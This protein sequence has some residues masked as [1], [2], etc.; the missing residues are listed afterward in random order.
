[1]NAATD[2]AMGALLGLAIGDALGMPSQTLGPPEIRLR[3]GRITGFVTPFPDH[4]VSHGLP[5]GAVTDDTEQALLLARRLLAGW[6]DRAWAGDLLGWEASV[7]ER[8]LR[9][10]LGPSTKR[11]LAGLMAG[12]DPAETGLQ[13]DT[14]GAAMRVAPVGIAMPPEPLSALVDAVVRT[15]RVTHATAPALAAASA[16]AAAISA[17]IAGMGAP[18]AT[19]LTLA[20]ARE[21][22]ARGRWVQG[23][24][25][26]ARIGWALETAQGPGD[27]QHLAAVLGTGVLASE[28]V[29][30]AFGLVAAAGG[31][32]WT[33]CLMAAN[34]GG[35]TD[36]VGAI[37]GA[38][39]GARTGAAALPASAVA[40]V[41]RVNGL[42]L[43][44]LV[45]GLLALRGRA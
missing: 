20:A 30:L 6:D 25:V 42:D 15:A 39:A 45:E 22:A 5:A 29:P 16:V 11:A 3:H 1:M 40:T 13:G 7:R 27:A 33:A 2:R 19:V 14:N 44:P 38:I 26:A 23:A 12:A 32:A 24:D 17:G 35:D 31:D 21:G 8:G 37:A 4:P 9:D 41:T 10:L 43:A 18:E 36:T 28:S 34:A